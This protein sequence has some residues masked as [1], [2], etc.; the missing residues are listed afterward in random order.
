MCT[1]HDVRWLRNVENQKSDARLHRIR[2]SG[3][4]QPYQYQFSASAGSVETEHSSFEMFVHSLFVDVEMANWFPM[5]WQLL[6]SP[7]VNVKH[8]QGTPDSVSII[9]FSRFMFQTCSK[10][11]ANNFFI[12]SFW[13]GKIEYYQVNSRLYCQFFAQTDMSW[14]I[15]I[16]ATWEMQQE[17]KRRVFHSLALLAMWTSRNIEF[18]R[19]FILNLRWNCT[20]WAQRFES[21]WIYFAGYDRHAQLIKTEKLR[22]NDSR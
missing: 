12:S 8:L 10:L 11:F 19:L 20:N 9:S 16:N 4:M 21:E 18:S 7:F 3:S 15:N 2:M 6:N 1:L 14:I 5:N 22:L 13:N 17:V